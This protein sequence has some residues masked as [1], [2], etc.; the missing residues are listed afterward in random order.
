MALRPLPSPWNVYNLTGSPFWQDSLEAGDPVHPLEELFVGREREVKAL[1]QTLHGAADGSSRQ[2]V[3]GAAGVG[4]TTL[5]KQMKARALEHDFLAVDS[6]VP[7]LSS[8]DASAV[9]GRVLGGIYDIIIANRPAAMHHRAMQDASVLVRAHRERTGGGSVS[10]LGVGA[11]VTQGISASTPADM[12][13]DGPR[14]LRD[15]MGLVRDSDAR[16]VLLH[17][18]NLENLSE[19]DATKAGVLL[20]DLRDP[21][22]MHRGLHVVLVGTTD[23]VQ[24]AVNANAQVRT[25]FSTIAL[26]PFTVAEVHRLLA[27]R[28][29]HMRHDVERPAIPPV[30]K[31]AVAELYPLFRGDLRGLLKAL[32]DGVTPNIGLTEKRTEKPR[33]DIVPSLEVRDLR[34][35]LQRRYAAQLQSLPETTRVSQLTTW[36]QTAPDAIMTQK[37]LQRLW[38]ITQGPVSTALAYLIAQGY[39]ISL[40]RQRGAPIDYALSGTSRLI[41]D[42]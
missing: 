25:I 13:I 11:G 32:E 7:I 4:K 2:A 38:H 41:F 18:N 14:V 40:P 22:L 31:D 42:P 6:F 20:R 3:A 33:V 39:V 36:G 30:T 28:Y 12:M 29:Q 27:S 16:G 15:L 23:A 10:I 21:M 17:V 19:A 34:P 5:V 26:E 8:D 35:T 37:D 9:F 1:L 24:A